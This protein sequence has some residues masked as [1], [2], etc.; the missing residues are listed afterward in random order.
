MKKFIAVLLFLSFC[1]GT[2]ELDI[3][4]D[5]HYCSNELIDD[6]VIHLLISR[7]DKAEKYSCAVQSI[8]QA[9]N[10][11][12]QELEELRRTKEEEEIENT[13]YLKMSVEKVCQ[14]R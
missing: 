8:R 4:L 12:W 10:R 2:A 11:H 3:V 13:K 5:E 7:S 14:Y 1:G 9:I 6:K